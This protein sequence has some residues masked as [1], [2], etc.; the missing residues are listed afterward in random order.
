MSVFYL[1]IAVVRPR[2]FGGL[3]VSTTLYTYHAAELPAPS[4]RQF[5]NVFE[6]R[7]YCT[8]AA[9]AKQWARYLIKTYRSKPEQHNNQ[10]AL[11][12]VSRS[13]RSCRS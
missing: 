9:Q 3:S 2:L 7:R 6:L 8:T 12:Q 11:F 1:V 5:Q 13:G 10:L 4:I